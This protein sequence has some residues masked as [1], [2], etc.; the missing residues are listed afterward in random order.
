MVYPDPSSPQ[1]TPPLTLM[2]VDTLLAPM[3]LVNIDSMLPSFIL[4]I[5]VLPCVRVFIV[6]VESLIVILLIELHVRSPIDP[7]TVC[8]DKSDIVYVDI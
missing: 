6:A 8:A 1:V 4:L 2:A 5:V 3:E 7:V